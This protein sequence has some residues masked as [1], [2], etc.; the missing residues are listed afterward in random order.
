VSA[1]AVAPLVTSPP[2]VMAPRP[3][4]FELVWGV[5]R[6]SR[7]RVEWQAPDGL[8]GSA[9]ADAFG[10]VAQGERVL[11]VRLS[12]LPAGSPV[13]VRAVTDAV[14]APLERHTSDWK[15]VRTLDVAAPTARIAVWNDTHQRDDTLRALHAATPAADLLVWNGDLC[16]DWTDPASFVPTVL[17]PAGV[18]VSADRPLAVVVGNH[19]VRGRWAYQLADFVATPEGRPYTAYRIGPVACLVLHTGEDKPDAHPSFEGRV[20]FEALRA[21]QA[22]WLREVTARPEIAD[23]PYRIVCCHIPL[24]WTDESPA[25]YDADGYDWFSLASRDAWHDALVEWGAQL[26]V[27]GHTH[28]PALLPATAEFPYAQLVAGGPDAEPD[29]AEAAA[30]TELSAD[31]GELRV[32]LRDLAARVRHELR[33]AP[34]AGRG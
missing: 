15:T 2:V 8:R 19:D 12:G 16:N 31:S 20:A 1:A 23:A 32:V 7:G 10:M 4:G 18:D 30:W 11:R 3:D 6:L 9:A 14:E 21:E 29:A 25:D 26:V 5:S 27:S 34:I 33:L 13:R 24:R 17:N 22:R 28:A